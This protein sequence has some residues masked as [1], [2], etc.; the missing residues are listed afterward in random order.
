MFYAIL[1]NEK[2]WTTEYE[3]GKPTLPPGFGYCM[4]T[5]IK[6]EDKWHKNKLKCHKYRKNCA[7]I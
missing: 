1:F 4:N 3:P 6:Q 5:N 2:K 7:R